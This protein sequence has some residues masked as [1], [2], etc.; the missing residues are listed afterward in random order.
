MIIMI[1]LIGEYVFASDSSGRNL[2]DPWYVGFVERIEISK[3]GTL[4]KIEGCSRWF[5][6]IKKITKEQGDMVLSVRDQLIPDNLTFY[7]VI[8][9]GN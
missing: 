2:N 9:N 3:F 6:K 8:K 5:K 1:K 7:K 4:Y